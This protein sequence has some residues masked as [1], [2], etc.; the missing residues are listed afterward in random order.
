MQTSKVYWLHNRIFIPGKIGRKWVTGLVI[1][2]DG[3][4]TAKVDA[5]ETL[6]EAQYKGQPYPARKMRGHLRK[7]KPQTKAAQAI[8]KQLIK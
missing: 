1:E 8:R 3:L 4:H 5:S 6:P 2:A 7:M